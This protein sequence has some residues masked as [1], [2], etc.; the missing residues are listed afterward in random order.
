MKRNLDFYY[1][2]LST[3]EDSLPA[4]W[5]TFPVHD[6]NWEKWDACKHMFSLNY[7]YGD[8]LQ[9]AFTDNNIYTLCVLMKSLGSEQNFLTYLHVWSENQSE[10]CV[11]LK[12]VLVVLVFYRCSSSDP[13]RSGVPGVR[14]L[15]IRRSASLLGARGNFERMQQW[16][17]GREC[18]DRDKTKTE[19]Q[20]RKGRRGGWKNRVRNKVFV[21]H[22]PLFS[23]SGGQREQANMVFS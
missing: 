17:M 18:A 2:W 16:Q 15:C 9:P 14:R 23:I 22:C 8:W 3:L 11:F 1:L 13:R 10:S 6:A 7:H 19:T 4:C 5:H 12:T 20:G 21:S